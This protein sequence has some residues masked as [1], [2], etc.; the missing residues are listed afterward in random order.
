[1]SFS[2]D[3]KQVKRAAARREKE[4]AGPPA[5]VVH[6]EY[7]K[8]P[9]VEEI[10]RKER[11][12]RSAVRNRKV[13]LMTVPADKRC[14]LC[15][16]LQVDS[17]NWMTQFA[18]LE[19]RILDGVVEERRDVVAQRLNRCRWKSLRIGDCDEMVLRAVCRS[20]WQKKSYWL[21]TDWWQYV[22]DATATD[23]IRG[24]ATRSTKVFLQYTAVELWLGCWHDKKIGAVA[25][26]Q[27]R[28]V[29]IDRESRRRGYK[30]LIKV[31]KAGR[32][33]EVAGRV[34]R[35]SER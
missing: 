6:R 24:R 2:E 13:R 7:R 9:S 34:V 25:T 33:C 35:F 27:R 31:G 17:K 19:E 26:G 4:E 20:C 28:P 1:M 18:K 29:M 11:S 12:S 32:D 23:I 14:D 21:R 22:L 16:G 30:L 15:G 10:T 8:L 5:R 3:F